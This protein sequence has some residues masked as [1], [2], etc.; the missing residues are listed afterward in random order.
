L[1]NKKSLCIYIASTQQGKDNVLNKTSINPCNTCGL[2][3]RFA[4]TD[5][6]DYENNYRCMLGLSIASSNNRE[7]EDMAESFTE[8]GMRI[9]GK[10]MVYWVERTDWDS[11]DYMDGCQPERKIL[12]NHEVSQVHPELVE[13][14][15]QSFIDNDYRVPGYGV[16]AVNSYIQTLYQNILKEYPHLKT[17][18]TGYMEF[19]ERYV[20]SEEEKAILQNLK[21]EH[22]YQGNPT[23]GNAMYEAFKKKQQS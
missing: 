1:T 17:D 22:T 3:A 11:L 14:V 2:C 19:M 5:S 7:E 15:I 9:N 12:E 13:A 4:P 20:D 6:D 23:M 8:C 16:R 10:P 21:N 18:M